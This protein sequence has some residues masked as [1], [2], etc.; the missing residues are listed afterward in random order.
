MRTNTEYVAPPLHQ[1]SPQLTAPLNTQRPDSSQT[2]GPPLSPWQP[3]TCRM[4]KTI[5][6]TLNPIQIVFFYWL[7]PLFGQF[8][9][10][11]KVLEKSRNPRWQTAGIWEPDVILTSS[12]GK[13]GGPIRPTHHQS[14]KTEKARQKRVNSS[15]SQWGEVLKTR[16]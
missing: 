15:W 7:W 1:W 3:L 10:F 6:L 5:A 8:W 13:E 11:L 2:N 12:D 9:R 14:Q 4:A 16:H